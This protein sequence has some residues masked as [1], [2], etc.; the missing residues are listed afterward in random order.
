MS[1]NTEKATQVAT[2]GAPWAVLLTVALVALK[3]TVAPQIP[4]V[5]VLFPLWFG[6]AVLLAILL[7][8]GVFLLSTAIVVGIANAITRWNIARRRRAGSIRA[9]FRPL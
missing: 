3:Y 7:I 4:W 2:R 6:P 9:D 1:T 8:V 5:W